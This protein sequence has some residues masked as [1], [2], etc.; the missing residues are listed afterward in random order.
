MV[1]NW[2]L[3][4]SMIILK[5]KLYNEEFLRNWVNWQEW[6]EEEHPDSD[7]SLEIAVEKL[8]EHYSEFT[9][10]FAENESGVSAQAIIEIARRI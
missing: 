8:I 5:E 1:Q 3:F 2:L 4:G 6:L 10:E 9:P 7:L